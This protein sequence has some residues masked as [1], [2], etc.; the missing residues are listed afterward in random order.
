MNMRLLVDKINRTSRM[1]EWRHGVLERDGHTCQH[2]KYSGPYIVVHR[3]KP[4]IKIFEDNNIISY[5]QAMSSDEVFDLDNGITLCTPCHQM[6]HDH[7]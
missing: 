2:C 7:D 5:T 6:Y 1:A 3:K 4:L